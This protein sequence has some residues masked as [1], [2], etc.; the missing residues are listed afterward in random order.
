MRRRFGRPTTRLVWAAASV[1]VLVAAAGA[2]NRRKELD[3]PPPSPPDEIEREIKL[4]RADAARDR[5]WSHLGVEAT[6]LALSLSWWTFPKQSNLGAIEAALVFAGS[7][8]ALTATVVRNLTAEPQ[9][10]G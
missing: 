6:L 8:V 2:P 7:A 10:S 5:F 3:V 9:P 1:A 4:L